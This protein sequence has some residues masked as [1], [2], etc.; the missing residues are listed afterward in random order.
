VELK[1]IN[2]HCLGSFTDK[3]AGFRV[4]RYHLEEPWP[5]IYA[6]PKLLLK[7]DQ[8]GPDYIQ[9]TPPGGS[10]FLRRE[11]Y[12]TIPSLLTWIKVGENRAFTNF[13][14]PVVGDIDA[15][16]EP[17]EFWCDYLPEKAH[18]HVKQDG[19]SCDTELFVPEGEAVVVMTCTV[20]NPGG[21]TRDIEVFP[22]M[23][24]HLAS[25]SLPAWDVPAL[26]QKVGY[27][28]ESGQTFFLEMRSPGGI[29]QLRHYAFV[30]SDLA[31]PDS[32][33]VDYARFVGS[34]TFENP[35]AL[36]R[37]AL[38][39]D[40]S[41]SHPFGEWGT[42]NSVNGW[43]GVVALRKRLR[44]AAGEA[45]SFTVVLGS[46]DVC[47]E[48]KPPTLE[49][50]SR[51]S[52]YFDPRFRDEAV[53]AVS[54]RLREFMGK[55]H[56]QTP[57][58]SFSRYVNEYLPLQLIGVM[59][60]GWA[61]MR[62]VR[63]NAQDITAFAPLDPAVCRRALLA[64][65][66]VQRSDGWFPRQYSAAGR[67]GMHDLRDYVDSG[68]WVWELLYDYLCWSKDFG[69]LDERVPWLDSDTESTILDHVTRLIG[70]YLAPENLGEHGLCLI[71]E[72]DW[73][74]SINRAGL[75]GRGESV[76]VSCQVVMMLQ[77][78]VS[79]PSFNVQRSTFNAEADRLTHAIL[80]HA[81]NSEG[82]LNGVFNDDGKWIFSPSD[83]DGK[84]RVN[85]P[86]NAFG[87]ISGVLDGDNA[88]RALD[89]LRSLKETDGWPLFTPAIGDPPISKL[90]RIG[91]GDL[92]PGLGENGTP[93]NHGCHGFFG[94]AAAA[95]G[96]GDLLFE[97]LRYMLS[98]DQSAHPI[99]RAK[100]A[101]YAIVNHWR[102][103]PGL[104][105]RGGDCFFSG[106]I[107]T[108]I[109]NVYDGLFGIKPTLDG[110][111]LNPA[112]P[113][114]WEEA[115]VE[116]TYL[117]ARVHLTYRRSKDAPRL[118]VNGEE[119][120][121]RHIDPVLRKEHPCIPDHFFANDMPVAGVYYF[122]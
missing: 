43:Q 79:V 96:D 85:V 69:L 16:R 44:L 106:S 23:R 57:D 121:S 15:L 97:I 72:G 50:I 37:D 76:M 10:F 38:G 83:P 41:K 59:D 49:E 82:Y 68:A 114:D 21:E 12:Q 13:Y 77:Q 100:T 118:L 86:V 90:G 39:V 1:D 89:V 115:S 58:Q 4:N 55:R 67:H 7:V 120:S 51:F 101:P 84:R 53:E 27:S 112:L 78:L 94:R 61:G 6:T 35:E 95:M 52:S 87:L 29:P 26:Y 65:F 111:A 34:G 102:T 99:D 56:I 122:V 80:T 25:G 22:T 70:Y 117:G 17:D 54:H 109:R 91:Q 66:E 47:A 46:T 32:A 113:S 108:A 9:F 8:R 92:A 42:Q 81:L 110:L 33:E 5:Y 103:A 88:R 24:P 48:G 18:Y 105:G 119:V 19:I 93:Y 60:R 75:E 74:D 31:D 63:D 104:E 64:L 71:R 30:L 14:G 20:T 62:G 45:F 36:R 98:Y 3:P 2:L 107:S 11:R 28:N 116:F 73:N 40:A